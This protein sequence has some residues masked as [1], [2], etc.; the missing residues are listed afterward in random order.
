MVDTRLVLRNRVIGVLLRGKREQAG[1][2][3]RECATALGISVSTITAWE[4]GRKPISLP[5]LE[6]LAY[7][8]GVPVSEFWSAQAEAEEEGEMLP[9]QPVMEVRQRVVGALLRQ[10]R[11]DAGLSVKNVADWLGYPSS[12]IAAYEYGERP[13]PFPELELLAQQLQQPVEYFLGDQ[14]DPLG[15]WHQQTTG[16]KRFQQLAPEVQEFV[17]QP[18][19]AQYLDVAM[20]LAQVPAER[21]RAIAESLLEITC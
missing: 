16:W 1:K 19:N 21:L 12:R 4:E 10:A 18:A 11:T 5:Q 9:L 7:V 2:T 20:K 3:K 15:R 13:I 6:A 8:F 17:L 14:D